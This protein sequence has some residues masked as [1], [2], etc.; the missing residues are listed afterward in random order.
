LE[1]TRVGIYWLARLAN[2]VDHYLNT[3]Q[4]PDAHTPD[5]DAL[6]PEG[7]ERFAVDLDH[8]LDIQGI[9]GRVLNRPTVL[10]RDS[11]AELRFNV[12]SYR[13]VLPFVTG[14]IDW[15]EGSYQWPEERHPRDHLTPLA[16]ALRAERGGF[17]VIGR[18]Q[19][20]SGAELTDRW[21]DWRRGIRD[22]EG[23]KTRDDAHKRLEDIRTQLG[24]AWTDEDITRLDE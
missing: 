4:P 22:F 19:P 8:F 3:V 5:W 18:H 11:E 20:L 24:G 7:Q 15:L 13:N 6:D 16:I 2:R 9:S 17:T 1:S 21:W 23:A 12:Q 10:S 14:E